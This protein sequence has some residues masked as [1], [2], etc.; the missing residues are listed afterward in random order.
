MLLKTKTNQSKHQRAEATNS[1]VAIFDHFS[2]AACEG[3]QAKLSKYGSLWHFAKLKFFTR[4]L[5]VFERTAD[6]QAAMN[7]LNSTEILPGNKIRMYFSIHTQLSI[8][9]QERFLNVPYQD[10]LWL[11]SPPG[12][13]P[14]D[15]RQT[16]EEPPNPHHLDSRI[17]AALKELDL[18]HFVLN[19]ADIADRD[20]DDD[21][22]GDGDD[23]I[24][25][26]SIASA[27]TIVIQDCD[28]SERA[29][30]AV[31]SLACRTPTPGPVERHHYTPT[32]R[33]PT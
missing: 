11:I 16:R 30:A 2:D 5:A 27:P 29:P 14:I 17:E 19:P 8:S 9:P 28:D 33:P 32:A 15:W 24:K 10:K 26:C 12:S 1:I 20:D 25:S 13:P 18:G 21:D 4:C 22:D 7:A 3:L 6:A 23:E 31:P